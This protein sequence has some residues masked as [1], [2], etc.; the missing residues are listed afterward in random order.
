MSYASPALRLRVRQ[1]SHEA[2]DILIL[3]LESADQ[4]SLPTYAPGAHIDLNLP[5]G[6]RRSYSLCG[7]DPQCGRYTIAVQKEAAGRGGSRWIHENLQPHAAIDATAPRNLFHL[8]EDAPHSILIAGGIGI[9]PLIAMA[10]RLALLGRS[11]DLHYATR[12]RSGTPFLDR[13][14]RGR[15]ASRVSHYFGDAPQRTRFRAGELLAAHERTAHVYVCGPQRL[16]DDVLESAR[17]LG[18]PEVNLHFE[19]FKRE[20]EKSEGDR[21]FTLHLAR[22]GKTVHVAGDETALHALKRAGIAVASSCEQGVC[23]SCVTRVMQGV[24]DHRDAYLMQEEK[25]RNDQFMP[26]CSRAYSDSLV[27]DL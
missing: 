24:C 2:Q 26:C 9:T 19:L 27:L 1:R 15:Y 21:P 10:D 13:L 12:T 17:A 20:I 4:S 23:G 7:P 14:A 6:S 16:I 18:W 11:F 8:E 22:S 25:E 5:D 3:E